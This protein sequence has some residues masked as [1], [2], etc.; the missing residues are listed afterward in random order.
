MSLSSAGGNADVVQNLLDHGADVN[1]KNDDGY[2][3]WS[4]AVSSGYPNIANLLKNRGS[5]PSGKFVDKDV[6]F[7]LAA[8]RDR[9]EAAQRLLAQGADINSRSD[10]RGRRGLTVL[11]ENAY[12][13]KYDTVKFLLEKGADVHA[14]DRSGN[15]AL[16]YATQKK[17]DA[18]RKL[19]LKYDAKD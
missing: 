5:K 7:R 16:K 11:M 13:G 4:M 2:T 10:S 18:V 9:L 1:A 8:T 3:P 14:R 15:T 12:T 6:A 19:L 17:H